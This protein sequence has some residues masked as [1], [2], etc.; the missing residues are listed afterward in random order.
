VDSGFFIFG[1]NRFQEQKV[2]K[3]SNVSFDLYFDIYNPLLECDG[4]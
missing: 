3:P 4:L 1:R 2:A